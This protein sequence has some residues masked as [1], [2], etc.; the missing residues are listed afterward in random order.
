MKS[1]SELDDAAVFLLFPCATKGLVGVEVPGDAEPEDAAAIAA[2][3][4]EGIDGVV[5]R[6]VPAAGV[7]YVGDEG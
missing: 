6:D 4:G 3:I 1:F 2:G 7:E 5:G